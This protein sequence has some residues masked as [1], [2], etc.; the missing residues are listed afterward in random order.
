[1]SYLTHDEAALRDVAEV[2]IGRITAAAAHGSAVVDCGGG[3]MVSAHDGDIATARRDGHQTLRVTVYRDGRCGTASSTG[4]DAEAVARTVAEALTIAAAVQSDDDAGLADPAWLALEG[5]DV[6][7]WAPDDRGPGALINDALAIEAAGQGDSHRV[8]EAGAATHDGAWALA[9]S[10]GFCRSSRFSHHS[11]WCRIIAPDGDAAVSDF[12][13][14][15]DRRL[16]MLD[17][18]EAVAALAIERTLSARG[19]H[20]IAS[21]RMPVLFQP[22]VAAVLLSEL[23]G[24]LSGVP[25]YSGQQILPDTIDLIEDPFEPFGLASA[26][27]DGDGV[28]GSPRAVIVGGVVQG[29]FLATRSARRLGMRSTGNGN[30]PYNL[31]L[32][33]VKNGGDRAA[34]L[35]RL[36]EGLVVTQLL[37]G[38]TDPVR[39]TWTRAV[40]G[41]RVAA[42]GIAHPVRDVTLAG[43]LPDMLRSIVAIGADVERMGPFRT[44][45]LLIDAMQVGG[46]A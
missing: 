10:A 30:G 28:A 41:F 37:G 22:S 26:P 27:F 2:A 9:T 40:A 31:S 18:V 13:H 36:G 29:L 16:P 38:A 12:A 8:T 4:F 15:E 23:V 32:R 1:M 39:G 43:S 42:G 35:A 7:L 11:R 24:A 44:G 5:P 33:A 6:P 3:A 17:P 45:S 20:A 25:Q 46:A 21:G 34:M 19:S 14:G